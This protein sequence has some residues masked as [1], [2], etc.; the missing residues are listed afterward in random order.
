MNFLFEN[1]E[2]VL[3]FLRYQLRSRLKLMTMTTGFEMNLK[4]PTEKSLNLERWYLL[5]LVLLRVQ[6]VRR[7]LMFHLQCLNFPHFPRSGLYNF[8][9][10]V[11]RIFYLQQ[12]L[13]LCMVRG[14]VFRLACRRLDKTDPQTYLIRCRSLLICERCNFLLAGF[15]VHNIRFLCDFH[16]G[17]CHKA[18]ERQVFQ[19]P[20]K[21]RRKQRCLALKNL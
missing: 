19:I 5:N 11:F 3:Q 9:R 8:H 12:S 4:K 15:L 21:L 6:L 17:R 1:L 13:S 18:Q 14:V 7:V 2:Q 16:E 20:Y 10:N